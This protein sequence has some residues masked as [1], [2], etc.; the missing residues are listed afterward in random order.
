MND[1]Q[2]CHKA[3]DGT[4]ACWHMDCAEEYT[5]KIGVASADIYVN[6]GFTVILHTPHL[7]NDQQ[8]NVDTLYCPMCG[9]RYGDGERPD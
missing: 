4:V 1:C 8:L 6:D 9:R 2:L 3:D 5:D 7:G